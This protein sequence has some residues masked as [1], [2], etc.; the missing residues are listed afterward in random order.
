MSWAHKKPRPTSGSVRFG[1]V[2]RGCGK[3]NQHYNREPGFFAIALEK[4]FSF[5]EDWLREDRVRPLVE[6]YL[7]ALDRAVESHPEVQGCVVCCAH[8]GIRFLTYPQNAR[9]R[10]LR[11]PFGCRRHHRRQRSNQRSAAYYRTREGKKKKK[12]LNAR[13]RVSPGD[14]MQVALPHPAAPPNEPPTEELPGTAELQLEGV[15]LDERSVAESPM[16][17]HVRMVVRLLE[18]IEL[19]CPEVADLLRRALRQHSMG[20]HRRTDKI[21]SFLHYHPP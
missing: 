16:L 5:R 1:R 18:G 21:L 13:R 14:C 15:V 3:D 6:Q 7:T 19:T 11:C 17:P 9:R 4:V 2:G 12:R 20:Q 10:N 8:C